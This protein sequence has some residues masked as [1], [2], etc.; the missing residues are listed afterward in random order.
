M[1]GSD[2]TLL[3]RVAKISSLLYTT[4]AGLEP[5]APCA[6]S[7]LAG[8]ATEGLPDPRV[9]VAPVPRLAMMTAMVS[10]SPCG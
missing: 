3:L 5:F 4:G 10:L 9:V 7:W 6:F 2:S 8:L 1:D